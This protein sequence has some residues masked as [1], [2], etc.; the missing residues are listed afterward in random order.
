M[1]GLIYL[2]YLIAIY[3]MVGAVWLAMS[4]CFAAVWFAV[5]IVPSYVSFVVVVVRKQSVWG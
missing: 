2:P 5:L 1:F 3:V 4:I